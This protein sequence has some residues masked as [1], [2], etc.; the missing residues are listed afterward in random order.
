MAEVVNLFDVSNATVTNVMTSSS[1]GGGGPS[2]CIIELTFTTKQKGAQAGEQTKNLLLTFTLA[3]G[4]YVHIK[5]LANKIPGHGG[6]WYVRST[7]TNM[8]KPTTTA[9]ANL[10]LEELRE[11]CPQSS[12]FEVSA[13]QVFTVGLAPQAPMS[14]L[15]IHARVVRDPLAATPLPQSQYPSLVHS[16]LAVALTDSTKASSPASP[17]PPPPCKPLLGSF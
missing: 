14:A 15:P 9:V 17:Q 4:E 6:V 13:V 11:L 8:V 12:L 1:R 2:R 3:H 10:I 5:N 16:V 7:H